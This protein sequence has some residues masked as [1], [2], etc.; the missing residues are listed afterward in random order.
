M[1]DILESSLDAVVEATS[2]TG[3]FV[4]TLNKPSE[5]LNDACNLNFYYHN[6]L[7]TPPANDRSNCH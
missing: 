7:Y 3:I 4:T 1:R 5:G 6:L 2:A